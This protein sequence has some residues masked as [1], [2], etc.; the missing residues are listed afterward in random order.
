[1]KEFFAE[2]NNL[3]DCRNNYDCIGSFFRN[4]AIESDNGLVLD[5]FN[6]IHPILRIFEV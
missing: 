3:Q 4:S 5:L 1:M 6:V 2:L